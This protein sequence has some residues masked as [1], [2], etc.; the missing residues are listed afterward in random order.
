MD[1]S[2]VNLDSSI[3]NDLGADE[4]DEV[5]ILMALEE[6]F[7]IEIPEEKT[8]AIYIVRTAV[9]FI[10]EEVSEGFSDVEVVE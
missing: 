5:E 10:Y 3:L 6:E 2:E 4:L 7:D 8:D 9:D 1:E